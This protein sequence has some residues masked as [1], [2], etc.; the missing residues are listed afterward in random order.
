M[1]SI[2]DIHALEEQ[3]PQIIRTFLNSRRIL[4]ESKTKGQ[5]TDYAY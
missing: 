2:Q 1:A 3:W 5:K 4:R